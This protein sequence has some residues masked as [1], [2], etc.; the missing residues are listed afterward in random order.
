[1]RAM[2]QHR[3]IW[4][5]ALGMALL[6]ALVVTSRKA[7]EN[8]HIPPGRSPSPDERAA[9]D[10]MLALLRD[11]PPAEKPET[12]AAVRT[13]AKLESDAGLA[14][15]E[16][17][18]ALGL[19]RMKDKAFS[20]AEA[21]LRHAIDCN[22]N[23]SWP[24]NGLG[25]LLANHAANREHEAETE[26]RTAMRLDPAWSRPYN[27]LAILLRM[28]GRLDEA[29]ANAMRALRLDPDSVA[30]LNNYGNLLVAQRKFDEAEAQYKKAIE[31]D[32]GHP[33]PYYNLACLYSLEHRTEDALALLDK[34]VR[35]NPALREDAGRDRDLEPIRG[36]PGFQSIVHAGR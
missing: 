27:D 33:K 22:P 23:W 34:A 28:T 4:Y 12:Q 16:T 32:P 35:L 1:M 15:A 17:F 10:A 29:E 19:S 3:I 36:N 7:G 14:T 8:D 6:A 26:F 20:A 2:R 31:L 30:A 25:I 24:H 21:A 5:F 9:I 11:D 13:V 18:Y